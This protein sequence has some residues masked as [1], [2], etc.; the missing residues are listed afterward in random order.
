MMMLTMVLAVVV[1]LASCGG[2]T[3]APDDAC[4]RPEGIYE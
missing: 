4:I 2:A 1:V 3:M